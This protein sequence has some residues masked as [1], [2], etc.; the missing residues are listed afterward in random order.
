MPC[1][2]YY[3]T[4]PSE[5]QPFFLTKTRRSTR[6]NTARRAKTHTAGKKHSLQGDTACCVRS[7]RTSAHANPT[8]STRAFLLQRRFGKSFPRRKAQRRQSD[9]QKQTQLSSFLHHQTRLTASPKTLYFFFRRKYSRTETATS[10]AKPTA[11]SAA[12]RTLPSD[13][14][15]ETVSPSEAVP[16]SESSRRARRIR[17]RAK[18]QKAVNRQQGIA[19]IGR[20]KGI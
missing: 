1:K 16:A 18:R 6:K 7:T 12:G 19:G 20:R 5:K 14:A 17:R 15:S 9:K 11:A 8:V 4:F 3:S 2:H 13:D 10:A